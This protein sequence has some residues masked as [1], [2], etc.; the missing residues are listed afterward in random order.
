[1]IRPKWW[2]YL[3]ASSIIA[4]IWIPWKVTTLE[5][6]D[7]KCLT[8]DWNRDWDIIIRKI[9]TLNEEIFLKVKKI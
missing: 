3:V 7:L 5:K 6:S 8:E 9:K 1:M 4:T 2:V